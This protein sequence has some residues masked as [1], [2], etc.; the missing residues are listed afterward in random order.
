MEAAASRGLLKRSAANGERRFVGGLKKWPPFF[1]RRAIASRAARFRAGFKP[2][3][4]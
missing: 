1:S 4:G 2:G 3:S